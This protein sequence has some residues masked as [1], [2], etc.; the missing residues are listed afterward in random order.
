MHLTDHSDHCADSAAH[1]WELCSAVDH[2]VWQ[3]ELVLLTQFVTLQKLIFGTLTGSSLPFMRAN[4]L[5]D[6]MLV[7]FPYHT[8]YVQNPL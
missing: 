1:V 2:T 7:T 6:Y 8:S 3:A 5:V 4:R